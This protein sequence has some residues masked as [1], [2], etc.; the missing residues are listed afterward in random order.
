MPATAR[1]RS[2]V[3]NLFRRETVERDLDAELRAYV[4]ALVVEKV[5]AGRPADV[6]RREALIEVGGVE[7]IKENVRDSRS[8]AVLDSLGRDVMHALRGLRRTPT[9]TIAVALTLTIG[10]GLN[11]SIFT[12]VYATLAR[13]LPVRDGR[14]V[15]NVYQ[16]V[17]GR[18]MREVRGTTSWISYG[19]FQ[20]YGTAPAF[21]SAAAYAPLTITMAG[22]DSPI[23]SELVT[24]EYFRT[25]ATRMALGRGFTTDEC[26]HPGAGPVVVLMHA[27]WSA[28]FGA[29]SSIVGRVVRVNALPVTIVGVA[30]PGFNGIA[31]QGVS[32]WIPIT[33]QPALAHGRDS[34][35]V[36]PNASWMAMVARLAPGATI[37]EASA[38]VAVTGR[39]L[40]VDH[41]GRRVITSVVPGAFLNFPEFTSEGRVPL[42]LTL[43]LGFTIVAMA[44]ANVMNLLLAR[45]LSR[46]REIAIRL[47][48]GA[49]RRQL[50]QQLLIESGLISI[51][52]ATIGLSFVLGLPRMLAAMSPIGALQIDPSPD[53]RVVA[54]A[55]GAAIATTFLIGLLPAL[56]ATRIDL[57]SAFNGSMGIGRVHVR[58]SRVRNSM[59]GVQVAGSAMLLIM[60]ALLVR[61]AIRATRA[62]PGY[63]V[64][65]VVAFSFNLASLGYDTAR[66][67]GLYREMLDR[68]T[69]LPEVEGAAITARLPLVGRWTETVQLERDHGASPNATTVNVATVSS[70]YFNTMGIRIVRGA[71]FDSA[72]VADRERGAVISGSMATALW[73]DAD[74]IGERFKAAG[75]WYRV[76]GVASE[77]NPVSLGSRTEPVAYLATNSALNHQI[78][79]R[80]RVS[81]ATLQATVPLWMRETDR[82]IV[83][84]SERLEDRVG[85]VL[86]PTRMVAASMAVL[87]VLALLLAAVGVAGVV[88]FGLGQRRREV[89]VRLAVGATG[90][91]VVALMMRQ[92]ARP[93]VA[94]VMTG[95][96]LAGVLGTLARGM[97]FGLSPIDPASYAT[98]I[99]VLIGSAAL[100][101]YLPA[102]RAG[103]ISPASTLRED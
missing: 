21:S 94:G 7:Q 9:F 45:G 17:R 14:R 13:P 58:P 69:H 37:D 39:R 61:G 5:R 3:R 40:D 87:G 26:A 73:R 62:D 10:I 53:M 88:S 51:A 38:Q 71:V 23:E 49:S 2:L 77:T 25:T 74:P 76:V 27:F 15:V 59:V 93:I 24:C 80:T 34:I 22:I 50:I 99:V 52:A 91:Q 79:V 72:F 1:I 36:R 84:S 83:V 97:L 12:L 31:I 103:G 63:A 98:M 8:S 11:T 82:Q 46:Q 65:N 102:R 92:G 32:L 81:P 100:A 89:A 66:A 90:G 60:S 41:P 96:V 55:I 16:Q 86:A 85:N 30:E 78:V 67:D 101:T 33:M 44:C 35:L 42:V 20:A 29:D 6:A 4:D 95:L 64:K 43:L 75:R 47:A 57:V 56:Q 54:Y 18:G 68:I 70:A 48:I 28:R 19:E